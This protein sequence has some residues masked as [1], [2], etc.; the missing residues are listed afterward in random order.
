MENR[1]AVIGIFMKNHKDE[2]GL[3]EIL[4]EYYQYLISKHE[5]IQIHGKTNVLTVVLEA[6]ETVTSTM[7]GKIGMLRGMQCQVIYEKWPK[8]Y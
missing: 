6:P 7:A 4:N 5:V 3:M 1:I 2:E 8:K